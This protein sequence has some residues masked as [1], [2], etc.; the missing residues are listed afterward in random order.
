MAVITDSNIIVTESTDRGASGDKG[1]GAAA[2][3]AGL[4]RER[5]VWS[6]VIEHGFE[7]AEIVSEESD[8]ADRWAAAVGHWLTDASMLADAYNLHAGV[9]ALR[10]AHMQLAC[11]SEPGA[12]RVDGM[13]IA[14]AETA[15]AA[16]DRV[17]QEQ[18]A[19]T[20]DPGTVA[21]R[22]L[23]MI[24]DEPGTSSARVMSQLNVQESQVSR[25]G[26]SL[27]ERGFALKTRH[28][29]ERSWRL[30]PRGAA[31]ARRVRNRA[32]G[33]QSAT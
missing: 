15:R 13:I 14:F 9:E 27:I 23:L 30:T 19:G 25:A 22:M 33:Q 5:L 4:E 12:A 32:N 24:D 2:R 7:G 17:R 26:R 28:G 18:L 16:L 1:T 8:L 31:L 10:S 6:A 11:A 29:R 3:R 21:A 20:L